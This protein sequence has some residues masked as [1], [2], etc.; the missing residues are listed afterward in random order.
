MRVFAVRQNNGVLLVKLNCINTCERV[1]VN[2]VFARNKL[3][4]YV[5]AVNAYFCRFACFFEAESNRRERV[6]NNGRAVNCR[7]VRKLCAQ[8]HF[9]FALIF[10]AGHCG[11]RAAE[12]KSLCRLSVIHKVLCDGLFR[13]RIFAVYNL[14]EVCKYTVTRNLSFAVYGNRKRFVNVLRSDFVIDKEP[15]IADLFAFYGRIES[16]CF[17]FKSRGCRGNVRA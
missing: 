3:V 6:E 17:A 5:L 10:R 13:L 7:I 12:L 11:N 15:L 16:R 4:C 9:A 8:A 2:A 1:G 14:V